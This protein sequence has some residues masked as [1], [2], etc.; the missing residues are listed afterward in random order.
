MAIQRETINFTL[1]KADPKKLEMLC[2]AV[3]EQQGVKVLQPP[4]QQTLLQPVHDPITNGT[5]YGGEILTTTTIVQIGSDS[6]HKGWAMVEDD[7]ETLSYRIAV[8]DGAFGA[9][10]F[11]G[12]IEELVNATLRSIA[13][14]QQERNQKVHATRVSFDLMAKL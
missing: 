1:Q 12:E 4:T 14:A 3:E 8:C 9:G 13:S 11:Q 7:N 5:F 10:L 2:Q 6:S